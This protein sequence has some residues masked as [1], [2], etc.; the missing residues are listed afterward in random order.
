ML[1]R[2]ICIL[3]PE[4][5]PSLVANNQDIAVKLLLYLF[6]RDEKDAR[7][8]EELLKKVNLNEEHNGNLGSDSTE[9]LSL[10]SEMVKLVSNY[11]SASSQTTATSDSFSLSSP[12]GGPHAMRSYLVALAELPPTIQSFSV[13]G[14]LLMPNPN[15][16]GQSEDDSK[17]IANLIRTEVLGAFISGCIRWIERVDRDEKEGKVHDDRVATATGSVSDPTL[18]GVFLT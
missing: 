17:R 9:S 18:N 13:L 14:K 10:V 16:S 4:D 7:K 11:G 15:Q 3:R 5:I 12:L 6:N 1:T 8:I 2:P